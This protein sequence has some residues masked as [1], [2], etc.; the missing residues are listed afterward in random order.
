MLNFRLC[1]WLLALNCGVGAFAQVVPNTHFHHIHLN[2]TDPKAAIAFYTTRVDGEPG[3]FAG[4]IDGVWA[5]SVWLLFN[6]VNAPPPSDPVSSIWHFDWGNEDLKAT[7]SSE[8]SAGLKFQQPLTDVADTMGGQKG[9]SF[10][11]L[12]DGPDHATVEQTTAN[13]HHFNSI[14]FFCDDPVA[15]ADWYIKTFG[16]KPGAK[17]PEKRVN[18]VGLQIGPLATVQ[19][20]TTTLIFLPIQWGM[21][22]KLPGWEGRKTLEN[23]KG[24][25]VDHIGVS[26]DNLDDAI[27]KLKAAGV[28]VTNEPRSAAG[29]KIKFAFIDGPDKTWIEVVEGQ[30]HKE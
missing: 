30:A 15:T 8:I 19:M 13:H 3:K 16:A 21:T 25:V 5:Q 29:G 11:A 6:K 12:L 9:R 23:T 14:H 27:A 26:V 10:Y 2:S 22:A 24:R 4:T 7:Y 20:D 1:R 17:S 28:H 18:S